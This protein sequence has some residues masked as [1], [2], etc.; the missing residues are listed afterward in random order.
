MK[1]VMEQQS[2]SKP[3]QLLQ[4]YKKDPPRQPSCLRHQTQRNYSK[5]HF[6]RQKRAQHKKCI[7]RPKLPGK[8]QSR[9]KIDW[10]SS[11]QKSQNHLS[12]HK[13]L[14]KFLQKL[15]N[16]L[17]TQKSPKL[18]Q[19]RKKL[20]SAWFSKNFPHKKANPSHAGA[21]KQKDDAW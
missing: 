2:K 7:K 16:R 18:T 6:I 12:T 15:R 19:K 8:K 3:A 14:S 1:E 13:K 9:L 4:K 5:F 20:A 21:V 11:P 17:K 10:Q